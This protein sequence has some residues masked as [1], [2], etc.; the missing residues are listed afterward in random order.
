MLVEKYI[1]YTRILIAT[2][3]PSEFVTTL[4]LLDAAPAIYPCLDQVL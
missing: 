2:Q 1:K 3:Y 4:S